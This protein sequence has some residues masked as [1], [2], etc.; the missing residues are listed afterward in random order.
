MEKD[1]K[2]MQFKNNSWG[3]VKRSVNMNNF[4]ISYSQEGG[5]TTRE[6]AE[7]AK[8]IDDAQYELDLRRIKKMANIQ[9][10][11][12]EYL[13]YWVKEI[14]LPNTEASTKTVGVWGIKNIIIPHIDQDVLLNYVTADYVNDIIKRC[15]PIC[16]SSGE[17][18]HKYLSRIM[19]DAY[20]YGLISQDIRKD[21]MSVN[22]K[23]PH[24]KLL[25][26]SDLR[27]FIQE[28]SKHPGYY[29][30]ILLALFA[31]LR[32][33]E[34]RG[35]R[36]EDFDCAEHTIR[37]ARQYTSNYHLADCDD[38]YIYSNFMEEKEPKAD[39]YRV[40]KVADFLFDE[41]ERKKAFN[42][43]IIKRRTSLGQID[44][45]TDY[46]SI[47]PYG[48][49][50]GKETLLSCVKRICKNAGVPLISPHTLRHQ[51][52]TMLIEKGVQL[53]EISNLLGH[54]S[55][56]T[57]FNIYCG[58]MDAG[59]EVREVMGSMTPYPERAYK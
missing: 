26:K 47:S 30:E 54:K 9:Y 4:T 37:I 17:T 51:F 31:G 28:A 14:F 50:K 58:V 24:I 59:D 7:D 29:F 23:V 33:G 2:D 1:L 46:V 12:K 13:E 21:L 57:T 36:Y 48:Q 22:R 39:S 53:E 8:D 42:D 49:R 38:H 18:A 56:L 20:E 43:T 16:D 52:A 3:Y 35:L 6:E 41:L 34:I 15:I 10:T 45:D 55:V 25:G 5:Y 40:L 19:N 44:I 27:K 11:F 32:S